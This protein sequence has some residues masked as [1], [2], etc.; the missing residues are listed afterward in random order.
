MQLTVPQRTQAD[1]GSFPVTPAG[2]AQWLKNLNPMESR[3]DAREVYRGLKHSNRLQNSVDQR[4]GVLSCFIPV[5]R[6]LQTHLTD[7]SLAQPLPLSPEFAKNAK[8][9]DALHREEAFAFKILLSESQAPLAD[10]AG[11]AMQALA[12][13]AESIVHGYRPIPDRLIRDAHQLYLMAEEH[14]LLSNS[15]GADL[16]SLQDHYRFILLLCVADLKQ[17]R[18]RQLPLL[19]DFL[20]SCLKDIHIEKDRDIGSLVSY[21][22][23]V[24]VVQGSQP[25]PALSLLSENQSDNRWFSVAPVLYR[26]DTYS[27]NLPITATA[28]LGVDSLERQSL[29]RL[30]GALSRY[31]QRRSA[32]KITFDARRVVFGHK[33]VCAHLLY[34]LEDRTSYDASHWRVVNSSSQGFCIRSEQCR[35]ALV[36]V[37]ELISVTDPDVPLRTPDTPKSSKLDASICVVRW[38]QALGNEG[39]IMGVEVMAKSV[40]PVRILRNEQNPAATDTHSA[41]GTPAERYSDI[42]V[43]VGENALIIACKKQNSIIQTLLTPPFLYRTVDSLTASQGGRS[44]TIELENCLQ[45]NG[46]FSQFSLNEAIKADH[47]KD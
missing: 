36:Q 13:Q 2:V 6:E 33:E 43:G 34:Q 7:M 22:Y 5:L 20:K 46:L 27:A 12:K 15:L 31:R 29:V 41:T 16:L 3:T 17:Q 40:L 32:R 8:L 9:A 23:A 28:N 1:S 10:D 26:I 39:I 42:N 11:R 24:N 21:D 37:G 38:V 44:R 30:H 19:V 14:G 35:A 25:E 4:R 18:V 45:N 47:E